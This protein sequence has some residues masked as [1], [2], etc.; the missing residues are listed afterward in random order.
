LEQD[1]ELVGATAIEDK[2]QDGVPNTIHQL[3]LA[4][5]KVWMLTGDKLETAQNIGLSCR[6][7]QPDMNVVKISES[8]HELVT[9]ILAQTLKKYQRSI[10]KSEDKLA[11][12]VSGKSLTFVFASDDLRNLFLQLCK[13]AKVVVACRVIP[14]QKAEL[15]KM[16][17]FGVRPEPMTLAIG[18]GANDVAMIQEAHVGVGISG[19][20]G[21]QAVRSS[22]YSF[23]QFRFL[24]RLL[25]VHGRWNY[26]RV[27]LLVLYSFY[28]NITYILTLFCF[29]FHN[30][31][32]GKIIAFRSLLWSFS[33]GSV[34]R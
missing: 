18:D 9:S 2:L 8:T 4:G 11:I 6:L 34:A 14:S 10:G 1:L 5:I 13:M 25:F 3:T 32:S 28:K 27:S 7:L 21:M 24:Q 30:S 12:L 19:N 29:G 33:M 23:A 16:V 15:V 17:R 20:E 26:R 31:Y 22:D